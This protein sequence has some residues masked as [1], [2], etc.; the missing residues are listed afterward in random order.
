MKNRSLAISL[1][2]S[3][4]LSLATVTVTPVPVMAA[5]QTMADQYQ[6]V[7][8][9]PS[10]PF[11]LNPDEMAE[12]PKVTGV[13]AGAR[14]S[15]LNA[16]RGTNQRKENDLFVGVDYIGFGNPPY[17][18]LHF[19]VFDG[20]YY[21]ESGVSNT[22]KFLVDYPD[23]SSETV[24]QTFTI[25]PAQRLSYTPKLAESTVLAGRDRVIRV[26]DLPAGANL[27]ILDTPSD[28][29]VD[30]RGASLSISAL[31]PEQGTIYGRV[32]YPDG[33]FES[34]VF[35]VTVV[36]DEASASPSSEP[37]SLSSTT[38]AA[39]VRTTT[40]TV[41][42]TSTAIA[43]PVTK[44]LTETQ[45]VTVTSKETATPSTVTETLTEP[46]LPVTVLSTVTQT[47]ARLTTTV[48]EK[49]QRVTATVTAAP[50]TVTLTSTVNA[51]QLT[52]TRA[53]STVTET[54]TESASPITV[55]EKSTV[56]HTVTEV[57]TPVTVVSTIVEKAIPVT[58]T[59][60]E[61]TAPVS[62]TVT[63]KA[64]PVTT[65]V[66]E[67]ATPVTTT[68]TEKAEAATVTK[69]VKE[70]QAGSSTGSIITLVIGLLGLIG[71]LGAAVLGNPQLREAL[72]F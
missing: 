5:E 9:T 59:V 31:K 54:I 10:K 60:T 41:T 50:E 8:P 66:T 72:P 7:F 57:A 20:Y 14:I 43:A 28:W 68:V 40:A 1:A 69:T 25:F 58:T 22:V 17:N 18:K 37:T 6:P 21:A 16:N 64:A 36:G 34:V 70:E 11:A 26:D 51:P 35:D 19:Q 53:P 2:S 45:T 15:I 32:N 38:Q 44:R 55:T 47:P 52:V 67:S 39:P 12:F 71:G 30:S 27:Q 63:E 24:E 49:A 46:G 13:P 56:A 4:A 48:T 42:A 3:V 29:T 62:T 61:N 23:G 33:S 65:T